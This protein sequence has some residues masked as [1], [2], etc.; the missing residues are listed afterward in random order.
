LTG[1]ELGARCAEIESLLATYKDLFGRILPNA[2]VA[3][4]A[5][6]LRVDVLEL[7]AAALLRAKE[8][9]DFV[10]RANEHEVAAFRTNTQNIRILEIALARRHRGP[11]PAEKICPTAN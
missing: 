3:E 7:T 6:A 2:H 11:A 10:V 8:F 9:A 1:P 5:Y 4:A